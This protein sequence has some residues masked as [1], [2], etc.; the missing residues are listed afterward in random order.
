MDKRKISAAI[1]AV[2]AYIRTGEEA[3]AAGMIEMGTPKTEK[4]IPPV[5]LN[6]WGMKPPINKLKPEH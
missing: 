3:A 1:A 6:L 4:T 5:P 2:T